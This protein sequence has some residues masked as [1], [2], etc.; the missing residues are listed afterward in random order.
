MR[1]LSVTSFG[2]SVLK[3]RFLSVAPLGD[4]VL[5]KCCLLKTSFRKMQ[6]CVTRHTLGQS[7]KEVPHQ[8]RDEGLEVKD[9]GAIL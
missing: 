3:K 2:E 1:F 8:V 5:K 4:S 6:I 9:G 7:L